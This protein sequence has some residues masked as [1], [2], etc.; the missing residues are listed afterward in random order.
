M[1]AFFS[2]ILALAVAVGTAE[3]GPVKRAAYV[4]RTTAKTT[5][6]TAKNVAHNVVKGTRRTVHTVVDA[7]TP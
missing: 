3:A 6:K 5:A 1:K 4:A 7:L 2:I